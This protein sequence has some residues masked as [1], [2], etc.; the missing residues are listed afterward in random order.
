MAKNCVSVSACQTSRYKKQ[1]IC[2]GVKA[3][4]AMNSHSVVKNAS[5]RVSGASA[6]YRN[7]LRK[8]TKEGGGGGR[9]DNMDKQAVRRRQQRSNSR[10]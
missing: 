6:M 10:H 7:T 9:V 3:R 5:D 1:A 4:T 2:T 8:H